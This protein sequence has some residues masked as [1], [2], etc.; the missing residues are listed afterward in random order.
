MMSAG[1]VSL[2]K[3]TGTML[4]GLTLR[5]ALTLNPARTVPTSHKAAIC[6]CWPTRPTG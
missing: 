3:T 5:P 1:E 4:A 2:I 6:E